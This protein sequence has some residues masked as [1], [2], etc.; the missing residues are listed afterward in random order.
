MNP[1]G[2]VSCSLR[3]K[4]VFFMQFRFTILGAII[5]NVDF[6]KIPIQFD[7]SYKLLLP[8]DPFAD[9]RIPPE[10]SEPLL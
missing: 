10:I 1:K 9:W 2:G 4:C 8:N 7:T 6:D 3:S 5:I